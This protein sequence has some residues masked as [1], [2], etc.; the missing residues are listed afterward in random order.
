MG[1]IENYVTCSLRPKCI[2]NN[3]TQARQVAQLDMN[4]HKGKE[5]YTARMKK[6]CDTPEGRSLYSKRM[7]CVEPVFGHLRS[8]LHLDRFTVRSKKK[9]NNQ[10]GCRFFAR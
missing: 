1:H 5:T 7:G 9:V 4:K 3:A 10:S 6:R 2:R 8:V